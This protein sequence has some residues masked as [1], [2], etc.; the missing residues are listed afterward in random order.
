MDISQ[1]PQD[2]QFGAVFLNQDEHAYAKVHFDP[3][4][5]DYFTENLSSV[6][7]P[8]TRGAIWRYFW[9]L[10]MDRKMSSLK[11]MDFVQQNLPSES[12]E[13]IIMAGLM[14]LRVLIS[15]YIPLELVKGKKDALF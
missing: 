4:S 2:F 12:V 1:L 9:L 6:E 7:D 3:Q 13:Q 15:S 8:L 10:V 5:I 11:Y 14:N